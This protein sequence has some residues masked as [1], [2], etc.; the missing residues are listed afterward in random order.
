MKIERCPFGFF[1]LRAAPLLATLLIALTA[2]AEAQ[3]TS[4][5]SVGTM[6]TPPGTYIIRNARIVTV[7][8]ADVENG[9]LVIRNGRIEAVGAGN[10]TAPPGAQ[11]IDA[12]G[13]TVYPGMMDA[14]TNMGLVEIGAVAATV[15]IAEV[16]D[17]NP[18][19]QAITA[20][21]PH[22]AS[23]DVTRVSGVTSVATLPSG[24]I[25]SGQ[26]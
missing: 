1:T 7:S 17:M 12:R 6:S 26:A 11:E 15:D 8:G 5:V 25:I 23:V 9:T 22:N 14:A 16:G 20:V 18:H 19:A 10:V 13:L 24:G 21:N 3:Q 4:S 2:I